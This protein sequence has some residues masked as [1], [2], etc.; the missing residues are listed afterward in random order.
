MLT[1]FVV[2][3]VIGIAWLADVKM[4][5]GICSRHEYKTIPMIGMDYYSQNTVVVSQLQGSKRLVD[6]VVSVTL[7]HELGHS[8]GAEHDEVEFDVYAL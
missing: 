6:A 1:L 5:S 2:K 7:I 8:F 4:K 3:D